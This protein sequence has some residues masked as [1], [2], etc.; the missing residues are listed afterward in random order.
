MKRSYMKKNQM[1]QETVRTSIDENPEQ[2]AETQSDKTSDEQST[3][4]EA[5][6]MRGKTSTEQHEDQ[7]EEEDSSQQNP[8]SSDYEQEVVELRQGDEE[9]EHLTIP[10]VLPIL[11]LKDTVIYPFAV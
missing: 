10:D 9:D 5:L 7:H 11:P 4:P 6:Q 1:K 2:S 3:T 8:A